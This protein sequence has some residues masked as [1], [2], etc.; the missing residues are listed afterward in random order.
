[1]SLHLLDGAA[2]HRRHGFVHES[3]AVL[4]VEDPDP[5]HRRLDDQAVA[6]LGVE[7]RL[8]RFMLPPMSSTIENA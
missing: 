4:G 5:L 7:P 2:E 1:M 6:L 3:G 8:L